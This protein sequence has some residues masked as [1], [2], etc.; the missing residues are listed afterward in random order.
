MIVRNLTRQIVLSVQAEL[1]DTFFSRMRGLLGREVFLPGQAMVITRCNS[2]H[3]FF[4]R[5]SI[6]AVFLD[7]A[8]CVVGIV[9]NIKPFHMSPVFWTA[10]R[11]IELPTGT[12]DQS[13]T[14]LGDRVETS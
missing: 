3:M 2:I 12:V 5:F 9:K 11:V 7:R 13:G 8:D 1:A 10:V 4:M 6:D 14:V